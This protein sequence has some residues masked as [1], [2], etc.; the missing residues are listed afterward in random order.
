MA[1]FII[2]TKE[3]KNNIK[4]HSSYLEKNIIEWSLIKKVFSGEIEFLTQ[5]LADNVNSVGDSRLTSLRNLKFILLK[6]LENIKINDVIKQSEKFAELSNES[7][8]GN[9]P[10]HLHFQ[11]MKD[12]EG[13]FGDYPGVCSIYEIDKYSANCLNPKYILSI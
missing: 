8:N 12:M 4:K 13:K 7:E 3:I 2:Y 5:N 9:W 1:E 11:V 6:S 10:P